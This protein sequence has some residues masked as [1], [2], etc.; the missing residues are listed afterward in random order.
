[1]EAFDTN[2]IVRLLVHDDEE[3]C[4]RAEQALRQAISGG[5]AWLS[6]VVLVE[7]CWV[8]RIAYRF[9]RATIASTLHQLLATEGIDLADG[10][11]LAYASNR[12]AS[13]WNRC[14]VR[15]HERD[16]DPKP[17]GTDTDEVTG[18]TRPTRGPTQDPHVK[19]RL[20][21][22]EIPIV[23]RSLTE[24]FEHALTCDG[25]LELRPIGFL[26]ND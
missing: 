12:D 23:A 21:R 8:L 13:G 3:Q 2:V 9:D 25:R 17:L 6:S 10:S 4:R 18:L 20:D 11:F 1:M 19:A 15:I 24:L 22:N 26:S 14:V 16:L 7:T 5:G